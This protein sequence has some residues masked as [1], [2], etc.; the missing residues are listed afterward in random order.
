MTEKNCNCTDHNDNLE[1]CE[2]ELIDEEGNIVSFELEEW[3]DYNNKI[4]AVLSD[5]EDAVILESVEEDGECCFI[6][7]TEEEFE[8]VKAYY[9]ELE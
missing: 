6:T 3:F 7:P 1:S 2:I 9:E 5:G 4:Y 8:K